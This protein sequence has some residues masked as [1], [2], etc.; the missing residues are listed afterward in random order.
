M[1]PSAPFLRLLFPPHTPG[2][3]S[4]SQP[5]SGS[6]PVVGAW[7]RGSPGF[8]GAS[9]GARPGTVPAPGPRR[10]GTGG[11][12]GS[13]RRRL[14]VRAGPRGRPVGAGRGH[15]GGAVRKGEGPRRGGG[16][17]PARCGRVRRR[18]HAGFLP[19]PG[20][21]A[22]P[23]PPAALCLRAGD[24]RTAGRAL[25]AAASRG[26]PGAGRLLFWGVAAGEPWGGRS[27]R[28]SAPQPCESIELR[29]QL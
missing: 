5:S 6:G 16:W 28:E 20:A 21:P 4:H 24:A 26:G 11:G 25:L 1:F 8:W 29:S 9:L 13:A 12:S 3:A 17:R 19:E 23:R 15:V 10:P 18:G 7:S 22:P 2:Q 27:G 14:W